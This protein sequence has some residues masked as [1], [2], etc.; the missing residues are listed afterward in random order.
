M[1]ET[2][3]GLKP[4]LPKGESHY[5][6]ECVPTLQ[7]FPRHVSKT[8]LSF[9][10]SSPALFPLLSLMFPPC[11]KN[12]YLYLLLF[13]MAFLNHFPLGSFFF[14]SMKESSK[15]QW[16][17]FRHSQSH[18]VQI[19]FQN[20]YLQKS[21][22]FV[23]QA[24]TKRRCCYYDI[25]SRFVLCLCWWSIKTTIQILCVFV[26]HDHFINSLYLLIC[27]DSL[28]CFS[29]LHLHLSMWIIVSC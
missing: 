28:F 16:H 18:L 9:A 12:L 19:H 6:E 7:P 27:F 20:H 22:L 2:G 8:L 26:M 10:L 14:C 29:N 13:V 17:V 21:C 1:Y 15:P 5:P 23:G 3:S 11:L 25:F 24:V 4:Y